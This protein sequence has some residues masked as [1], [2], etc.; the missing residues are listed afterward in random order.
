MWGANFDDNFNTTSFSISL[1]VM[2][3]FFHFFKQAYRAINPGHE[4]EN[5][6]IA[7]RYGYF[8]KLFNYIKVNYIQILMKK[9]VLIKIF[10][11]YNVH[12]NL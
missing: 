3:Y 6:F 11:L 12:L 8:I 9:L 5:D 7:K 2:L 1:I 4:D 10:Y